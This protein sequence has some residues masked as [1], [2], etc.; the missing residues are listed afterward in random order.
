M[1]KNIIYVSYDGLTD[2]LGQSQVVPYLTKISNENKKIDIIS[3]EKKEAF[4]ISK[5]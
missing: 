5:K 4:E 2:P 3:F 1:K